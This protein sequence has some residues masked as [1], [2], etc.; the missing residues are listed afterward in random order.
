M[1]V[2]NAY[3]AQGSNPKPRDV[4]DETYRLDFTLKT[5]APTCTCTGEVDVRDDPRS[6]Y[7]MVYRAY[8]KGSRPALYASS[9][10]GA[11]STYF[12][13]VND[14]PVLA[15]DV[16][17]DMGLEG[18]V[19]VE[20]GVPVSASPGLTE[21]KIGRQWRPRRPCDGIKLY[22]ETQ[23]RSGKGEIYVEAFDKGV[24]LAFSMIV[25]GSSKEEISRILASV[26]VRKGGNRGFK[27]GRGKEIGFGVVRVE[28]FKV[29]KLNRLKWVEL[30]DQEVVELTERSTQI[31]ERRE[32]GNEI[33]VTCR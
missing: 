15:G 10:K 3:R 7:R 28:K 26:G 13:A 14:D 20:D 4:L 11:I 12:L 9:I 5:C 29:W 22:D 31:I 32:K 30:R 27:I 25:Y 18:R 17:G 2:N 1:K 6:G 23:L 8:R 21:Q 24:S 19:R 16:F 33:F